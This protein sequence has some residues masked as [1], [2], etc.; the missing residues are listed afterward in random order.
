MTVWFYLIVK[1]NGLRARGSQLLRYLQNPMGLADLCADPRRGVTPRSAVPQ[2]LSWK[3]Y[4]NEERYEEG[5][6]VQRYEG[7]NHHE[8]QGNE[9]H[10]EEG[11]VQD[12]NGQACEVRRLPWQQGEDLRWPRK[13]PADEEQARQGCQQED[14]RQ[15]EDDPE[16]RAALARLRD[17]GPEG[18]GNQRLLCSGWQECPGQ[19]P[20]CQ[21]EGALCSLSRN[22]EEPPPL[23]WSFMERTVPDGA[24]RARCCTAAFM[25]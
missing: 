20:V 12:R 16:V 4:H 1:N 9:G 17:D 18:A 15:G 25:G 8:G 19:S 7:Q 3:M 14:A 6:E 10:E 2:T 22:G 24:T 11:R 13:V 23:S 5:D 21:G